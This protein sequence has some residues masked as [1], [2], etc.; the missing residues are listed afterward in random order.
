MLQWRATASTRAHVSGGGDA[1]A[2][3]ACQKGDA[4]VRCRSRLVP[5]RD[6]QQHKRSDVPGRPG[7]Y[8]MVCKRCTCHVAQITPMRHAMH[9]T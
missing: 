8:V 5:S 3:V 7:M 6:L 9:D 4:D 1:T 2:F